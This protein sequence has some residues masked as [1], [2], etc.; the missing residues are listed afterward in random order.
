M[1]RAVRRWLSATDFVK[2]ADVLVQPVS[3]VAAGRAG[4]VPQP[5]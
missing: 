4:N 2:R 3:T 5:A 1:R